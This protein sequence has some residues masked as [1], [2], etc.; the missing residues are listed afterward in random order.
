[1]KIKVELLISNLIVYITRSTY[2]VFHLPYYANSFNI[3]T[4]AIR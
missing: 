2:G 1:M 4:Q 3:N